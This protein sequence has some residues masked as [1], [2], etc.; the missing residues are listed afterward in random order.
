MKISRGVRQREN[1][2]KKK[3]KKKTILLISASPNIPVAFLKIV[4]GAVA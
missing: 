3:K 1:T 2:A 4:G